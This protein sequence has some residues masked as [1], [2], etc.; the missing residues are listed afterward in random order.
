MTALEILAK[1]SM[2]IISKVEARQIAQALLTDSSLRI[3]AAATKK[4]NSDLQE[5]ATLSL[6]A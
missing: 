5:L 6:A 4:I 3:A 2:T 1:D